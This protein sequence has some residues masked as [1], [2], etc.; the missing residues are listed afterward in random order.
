MR[1]VRSSVRYFLNIFFCECRPHNVRDYQ[2][3]VT[4]SKMGHVPCLSPAFLARICRQLGGFGAEIGRIDRE[5]Q[6]YAPEN[7][8]LTFANSTRAGDLRESPINLLDLA[9]LCAIYQLLILPGIHFSD[10]NH[11]VSDLAPTSQFES[12]EAT[13][14]CSFMAVVK[15]H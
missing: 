13:L 8:T 7:R 15:L 5:L 3:P 14:N 1:C 10:H 11:R 12:L 2:G 4:W 9:D 6:P